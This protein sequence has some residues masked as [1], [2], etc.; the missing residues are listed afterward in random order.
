MDHFEFTNLEH[1]QVFS[2]CGGIN[3][4]NIE[5]QLRARQIKHFG[6]GAF[7]NARSQFCVVD[8]QIKHRA[9][10][11]H[12]VAADHKTELGQLAQIHRKA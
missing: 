2:R 6:H 8:H 11:D 12:L 4:S 5:R 1:L 9:F 3:S 10:V 7:D